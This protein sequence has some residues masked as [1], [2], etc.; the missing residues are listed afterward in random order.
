MDEEAT[1]RAPGDAPASEGYPA[2]GQIASL[3]ERIV[4]RP[5][6]PNPRNK[7]ASLLQAQ[8]R[9]DE[10]ASLLRDTIDS[11]PRNTKARDQLRALLE[12]PFELHPADLAPAPDAALPL[13]LQIAPLIETPL[14]E[15]GAF[16]PAT[17][18]S[19]VQE[20][21]DMP[22]RLSPLRPG[23][24]WMAGG[25]ILLVLG[26]AWQ[27][28]RLLPESHL[29]QRPAMIVMQGA[30]P[31]G[32]S[33]IASSLRSPPPVSVQAEAQA[34]AL[35][36]PVTV[37]QKPLPE[38]AEAMPQRVLILHTRH[39]AASSQAALRMAARLEAQHV[40]VSAS[41]TVAGAG[42]LGVGYFYAEDLPEAEALSRRMPDIAGKLHLISGAARAAQQ[43]GAIAVVMP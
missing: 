12:R 41:M 33:V 14:V 22:I 8:G 16:P 42:R 35:P 20:P 15:Q 40:A 10:A 3:R 38:L 19:L 27:V 13:G 34:T 32:T 17:G 11:F 9:A 30:I 24:E 21:R 5:G 36:Q 18:W 28:W 37:P 6:D 25:A 4:Q 1:I 2:A 43:P 31:V 7:L 23:A 29:L 39:D 26:V